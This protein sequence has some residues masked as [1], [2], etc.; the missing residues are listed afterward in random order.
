MTKSTMMIEWPLKVIIVNRGTNLKDV[1][2]K[3][4]S[5]FCI[6]VLGIPIPFSCR[7]D[8]KKE[9]IIF[10]CRLMKHFNAINTTV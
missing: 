7:R 2:D 9:E 8:T 10:D 5:M 4:K 6:L 3:F 1:C